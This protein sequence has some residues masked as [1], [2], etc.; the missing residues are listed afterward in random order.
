MVKSG[1]RDRALIDALERL[2]T[3]SFEGTVWRITRDGRDPMLFYGGGNRW[4][5]GT[6]D[7]LYTSFSRDGALAEMRFHLS[8]GQPLIPSKIKYR[9]HELRIRI[10]D[11][12]DLTD[13]ALLSEIGIDM[14]TFGRMPYLDREGEYEACQRV[15]EAVHFLGSEDA[16]DPSA[17]RVPSARS[18]DENLVLFSDY[19]EPDDVEHVKDYGIIDWS[20]TQE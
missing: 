19:V 18:P 6:F 1:P 8:R 9:L 15:A 14:G 13:P 17:I 16:G 4:D 5:D 3:T 11:V 20:G 12:L 10:A 7:V 2:E